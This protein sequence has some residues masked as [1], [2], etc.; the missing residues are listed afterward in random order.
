MAT[1]S[2]ELQTQNGQPVAA[3]RPTQPRR[4]YS[5]RTDVFE[6]KDAIV[7]VADMPGV[8]EKNLEIVLERNVLTLRGKAEFE[9]PKEYNLLFSEYADGDYERSF[10][11]SD[12]VDRDGIDASLKHGVLRLRLPKIREAQARRITVKTD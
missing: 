11:L 4:I 7:V 1:Q 3:V 9:A 5:P 12:G 6:T 10:V 2:S 8:E